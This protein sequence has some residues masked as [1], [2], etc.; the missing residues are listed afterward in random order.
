DYFKAVPPERIE[1]YREGYT[2][3]KLDAVDVYKI[4]IRP[5]HVRRENFCK[6]VYVAPFPEKNQ[7]FC[8]AK[9]THDDPTVQSECQDPAKS[10]PQGPRGGIQSYNNG[11]QAGP[12]MLYFSEIEL[13]FRHYKINGTSAVASGTHELLAYS[14]TKGQILEI[15]QTLVGVSAALRMY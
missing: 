1:A 9:L 8:V 14:G 3:F 2:R 11:P 4:A 13:Q 6:A 10:N 7:W 5:E 12:E 15:A